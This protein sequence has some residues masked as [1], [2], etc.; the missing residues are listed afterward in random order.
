MEDGEVEEGMLI[1][2]DDEAQTETEPRVQKSPH[3]LLRETKA[4]VE[5]IVAQ[6]LAIKRESRPKA[7]LRE[8]ATQMFIHF[9]NL[10]QVRVSLKKKR[11]NLV[12]G[13]EARCLLA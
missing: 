8:L 5:E 11:E 10:R 7:Q 1:E 2:E 13:F 9:V 3:E 6:M 12:F 4:S